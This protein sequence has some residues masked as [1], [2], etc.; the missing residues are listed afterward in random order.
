MNLSSPRRRGPIIPV[1]NFYAE[2]YGFPLALGF[3]SLGGNDKK[4]NNYSPGAFGTIA[5]ACNPALIS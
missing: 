4:E 3:A 1:L 2:G 5:S